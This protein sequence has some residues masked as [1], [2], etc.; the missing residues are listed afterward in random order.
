MSRFQFGSLLSSSNIKST[1]AKDEQFRRFVTKSFERHINCDWGKVDKDTLAEN[2][3]AV[4]SG[5]GMI[6][7][8]YHYNN[9][10]KIIRFKTDLDKNQTLV[11][12]FD[13][14]SL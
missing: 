13:E 7:S 10:E 11:L 8:I 6:Y 5:N 9:G 2:E 14:S 1:M 3:Q 4:V 12:F